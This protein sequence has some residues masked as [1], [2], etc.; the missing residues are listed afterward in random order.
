MDDKF[1]AIF[2]PCIDLVEDFLLNSEV[3]NL[4]FCR[5]GLTS[6]SVIFFGGTEAKPAAPDPELVSGGILIK[7]AE[8]FDECWG[9]ITSDRRLHKKFQKE[10]EID[11]KPSFSRGELTQMAMPI[12]V[13]CRGI[14]T[15]LLKKSASASMPQTMPPPQ[16]QSNRLRIKLLN[17]LVDKLVETSPQPDLAR[18]FSIDANAST[19]M[20][21]TMTLSQDQSTRLRNKLL[22]DLDNML[23]ESIAQPELARPISIDFQKELIEPIFSTQEQLQLWA[24]SWN[25]KITTYKIKYGY[26]VTSFV[27]LSKSRPP[28]R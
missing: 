7:D 18:P 17:D 6:S 25:I 26:S 4:P 5:I 27:S 2:Q 8:D 9:I 19:S 11:I 14:T 16:D 12:E 10:L 13:L 24:A 23:V 1:I 3:E 28:S 21:K 20:S 22:N 15:S